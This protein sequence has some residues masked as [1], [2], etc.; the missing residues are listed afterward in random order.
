MA[1]TG[2]EVVWL[3]LPIVTVDVL[4]RESNPIPW[5]TSICVQFLPVSR[6]MY[7]NCT[8]CHPHLA[9][10]SYEALLPALQSLLMTKLGH[11]V[12]LNGDVV[13]TEGGISDMLARQTKPHMIVRL[14]SSVDGAAHV[15]HTITEEPLTF[16]TVPR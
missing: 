4:D 7:G 9:E 13:Q 1:E 8:S 5:G 3:H 15:F 2:G 12:K 14:D 6:E 11:K 16:F 10:R